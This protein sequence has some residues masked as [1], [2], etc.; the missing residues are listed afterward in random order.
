MDESVFLQKSRDEMQCRVTLV[1]TPEVPQVIA[2]ISKR[3]NYN[4]ISDLQ[5]E[6]PHMQTHDN[7]GEGIIIP[8]AEQQPQ[9]GNSAESASP[10]SGPTTG[11][12]V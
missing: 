1:S 5:P 11:K 3:L 2:T 7:P 9:D 8:T 10:G 4:G 6:D 12:I